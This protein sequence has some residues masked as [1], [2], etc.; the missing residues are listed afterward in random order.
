MSETRVLTKRLSAGFAALAGITWLLLIFGSTV[1]VHGAGL[2]CPDWPLCFGEVIPQLNFQVFLEWGHRVLAGSIS[3]GGLVLGSLIL[4]R[5]ELR[6]RYWGHLSAL[7][8]VLACQI[9]LGG[10]T[11]L[12]L[13]AYWSVTL[14]LLFGNLFMVLLIVL[15]RR[16]SVW[17]AASAPAA[18]PVLRGVGVAFAAALALQMALGGLVSSNYAGL[19]CT[20]WPTCS[21][22]VWFPTFTGIIGLQLSHRLGAY[23]LTGLAIALGILA[24]RSGAFRWI[25]LLVGLVGMQIVLGILNVL[26]SMPVELAIAHAATA[27]AI[28]AATSVVLSSFFMRNPA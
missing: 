3:V 16:L 10:L 13:L 22:G 15:A 20:E 26:G 28:V 17:E 24:G 2:S 14:H 6:A 8:L 11:V 18:P 12:K 23:L 25:Y 19:A 7:A 27:H 4:S 5:R 21:G 9:V 1:R